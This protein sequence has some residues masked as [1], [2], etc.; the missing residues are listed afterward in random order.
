MHARPLD[1]AGRCLLVV[2]RLK[3]IYA[4]K[5]VVLRNIPAEL[6]LTCSDN[7]INGL[8]ELLGQNLPRNVLELAH[9][10]STRIHVHY[11]RYSANRLHT[12]LAVNAKI[13]E[14]LIPSPLWMVVNSVSLIQFGC[15]S[16]G[17]DAQHFR[18]YSPQLLVI[19]VTNVIFHDRN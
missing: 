10:I 19:T 15:S 18:D 16:A 8:A 17:H 6:L 12:F 1:A 4:E 7:S 9:A 2:G 3:A 5:P 11:V 13:G 14:G